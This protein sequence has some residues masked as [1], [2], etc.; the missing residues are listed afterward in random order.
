ML[1]KQKLKLQLKA[2]L[3]FQRDKYFEADFPQFTRL[4]SNFYQR[5]TEVQRLEMYLTSISSLM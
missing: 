3:K 4:G 2:S 5:P 1:L